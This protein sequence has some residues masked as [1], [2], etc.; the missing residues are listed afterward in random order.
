MVNKADFM[1]LLDSRMRLYRYELDYHDAVTEYEK[2]LA[3][4]EAATGTTFSR[5][6]VR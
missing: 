1:T 4:L 3:A 2:S 5:E 6:V